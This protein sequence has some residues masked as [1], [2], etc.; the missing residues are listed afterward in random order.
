VAE[1]AV[2]HMF[3]LAR[4]V[5]VA[6]VTMRN[7]EWNKK[8]YKGIELAGK[9]L[10]VIGFGRIGQSLAG[11]AKAIGMNVIGFDVVD[12]DTDF[13][14]TKDLD[15]VLGKADFISLHVPNLGKPLVDE[16]FLGKLKDGSYLINCARGGVADEAAVLK[17]LNDGKLAGYG[18]DVYESEPTD[19]SELLNHPK[20]SSTPHIGAS[21][22]EAQARVGRELAQKVVDFFA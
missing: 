15:S 11:K 17:A 1:L 13:E 18:V 8:A 22:G 14:F 9:T 10:L 7:G 19:N 4:F 6:N 21:T 5:H 12:L 3:A 16:A 20:V 2:A